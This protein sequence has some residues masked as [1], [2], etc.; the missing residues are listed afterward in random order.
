MDELT[1]RDYLEIPLTELIKHPDYSPHA[2][3]VML[4]ISVMTTRQLENLN[5]SGGR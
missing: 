5:I 4:A 3:R 2:R 1:G